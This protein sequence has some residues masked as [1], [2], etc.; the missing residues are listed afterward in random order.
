MSTLSR[1]SASPSSSTT[2]FKDSARPITDRAFKVEVNIPVNLPLVLADRA[3]MLLA[4][5]NRADNAIRYPLFGRSRL[6]DDLSEEGRR[7]GDVEV[8]DR[9]TGISPKFRKI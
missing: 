1:R 6:V 7:N 9:G 3:A 8:R 5:A 4:F 2:C